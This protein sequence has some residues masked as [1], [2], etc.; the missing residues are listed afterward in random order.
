MR[1]MQSPG[2]LHAGHLHDNDRQQCHYTIVD[3]HVHPVSRCSK[4]PIYPASAPSQRAR[5]QQVREFA[6]AINM[7]VQLAGA[8]NKCRQMQP[9][10][11]VKA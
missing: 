4:Q 3:T 7:Q 6:G 2:C 9:L 10:C 8:L 5:T 1:T 11:T